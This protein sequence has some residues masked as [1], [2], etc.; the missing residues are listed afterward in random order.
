M[1]P[2]HAVHLVHFIFL[3]ASSPSPR[4]GLWEG[5]PVVSYYLRSAAPVESLLG[6]RVGPALRGA[7]AIRLSYIRAKQSLGSWYQ[8]LLL[9]ADFDL[10]NQGQA[11]DPAAPP[12]SSALSIFP[13]RT[14]FSRR[15]SNF[16]PRLR[17]SLCFS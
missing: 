9:I 4:S 5:V 16:L 15:G 1:G 8:C 6:L 7:P 12:A 2:R 14:G 10:Q 17:F 3:L 11:A 13:P